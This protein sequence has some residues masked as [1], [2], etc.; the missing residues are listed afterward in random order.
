MDVIA[1]QKCHS[2]R[3]KRN[4]NFSV[5]CSRLRLDLA[6]RWAKNKISPTD[7][8]PRTLNG[9]IKARCTDADWLTLADGVEL[10]A[11]QRTTWKIFPKVSR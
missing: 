4:W 9:K 3:T 7:D 6:C 8:A 1:E 10:L 2:R 11:D 5:I